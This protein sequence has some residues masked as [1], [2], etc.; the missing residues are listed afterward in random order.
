MSA[1][2][3]G[4]GAFTEVPAPVKEMVK[5]VSQEGEWELGAKDNGRAGRRSYVFEAR[6]ISFYG[7]SLEPLLAVIQVRRYIENKYG[8]SVAKP[9]FLVGEDEG[10]LFAHK[11]PGSPLSWGGFDA[12]SPEEVVETAQAKIF[13]LPVER[14]GEIIRQGDVA[15]VPARLI[16]ASAKPVDEGGEVHEAT[17]ADSHIVRVRGQLFQ[18]T[19][20][21]YAVGKIEI[22]HAKGQ[23]ATVVYE[24]KARIIVGHR[25]R[26]P[27]W[28]AW[29][30]AD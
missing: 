26:H 2:R 9:Y 30:L 3:D 11:L 15:I 1:K 6:N 24:G 17:L 21:L 8:T 18:N 28:M 19:D 12:M 7:Y 13:G 20:K 16:P 23:H 5:R 22:E 14:L 25:G 27:R 4:W 10:Q 29:S